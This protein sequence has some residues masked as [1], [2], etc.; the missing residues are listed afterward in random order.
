MA[1]NNNHFYDIIV[2]VG[3]LGRAQLSKSLV[4]L[5]IGWESLNG[6]QLVNGLSEVGKLWP[7]SQTSSTVWFYRESFTGTHAY[8]FTYCLCQLLALDG[9]GKKSL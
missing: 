7:V 5:G 4:L 1:S 2:W 6:I 3:N 9:R 8:S